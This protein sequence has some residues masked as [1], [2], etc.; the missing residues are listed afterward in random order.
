MHGIIEEANRTDNNGQFHILRVIKTG[1]LIT[2]YM[3]HI[4][5]MLIT[6][7]HYL[8]EQIKKGT[9][10]LKNIFINTSLIEHNRIFNLYVVGE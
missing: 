7:K 8:Q 3:R 2:Y 9:G 6:M 4:C 5:R 1:R 10:H